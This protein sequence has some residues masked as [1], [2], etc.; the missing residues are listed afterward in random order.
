MRGKFRGRVSKCQ[1]D[2]SDGLVGRDADGH[3]FEGAIDFLRVSRGTLADAR[4]IIEELNAWQFDGPF[5]RDFEG[6]PMAGKRRDAGG[7]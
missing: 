1:T 3:C 2:P 6:R 5:L 4:T 7:D